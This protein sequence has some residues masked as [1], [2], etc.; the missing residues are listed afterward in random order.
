MHTVV[1]SKGQVVIPAK[2]R[3]ALNLRSGQRVKL[4]RCGRSIIL[5]PEVPVFD[6]WLEKRR[7]KG[8]A[9]EP[10]KVDRT[11]DMPEAKTL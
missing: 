7:K 2:M 5:S 9:K 11:A 1:S 4:D 8:I 6:R 3:K 10:L